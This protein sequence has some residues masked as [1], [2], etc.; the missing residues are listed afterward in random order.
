[1]RF[2]VRP[3]SDADAQA[4]AAWRYP[5]PYDFYDAD[6]DPD[7]LAELLDERMRRATYY[8]VEARGEL[9]GFFA[10]EL[11][12]RT[13]EVGLGLRPDLTGR[14]LG[15]PFLAAGLR[16]AERQYAPTTFRLAVAA[17]NHRAIR[18][19]ERAGF[20]ATTTFQQH[21][22]GGQHEFVRMERPAQV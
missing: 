20:R 22:N 19:Y 5:P 14:G 7:D 2:L 12:D 9:V 1:V 6:Q 4:I 16:F 8:A 11:D 13:V 21:T 17:F 15:R 10:F 3:L 18:V